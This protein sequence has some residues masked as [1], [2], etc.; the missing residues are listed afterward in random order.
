MKIYQCC[1][2]M[3]LTIFFLD[4]E[5]RF[6]NGQRCSTRLELVKWQRKGSFDK[7]CL[8]ILRAEDPGWV[9]ARSSTE[10]NIKL[11]IKENDKAGK[12]RLN[13]VGIKRIDKTDMRR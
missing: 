8:N 9:G 6:E 10:L 13:K 7:A 11:G 1:V 4:N 2:K 3:P 12:E 5:P